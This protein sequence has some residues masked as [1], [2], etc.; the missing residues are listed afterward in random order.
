[1]TRN[2]TRTVL[3]TLGLVVS[4]ATLGGC[5]QW[6]RGAV[7]PGPQTIATGAKDDDLEIPRE[8]SSEHKPT[9]LSGAW[10]NEAAEIENH[11]GINR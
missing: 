2:R 5:D 6:R 4:L 10:S 7:R 3:A 1:M 8:A 11:F 9:R